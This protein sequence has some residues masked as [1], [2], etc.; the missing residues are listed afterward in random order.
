[1][2]SKEVEGAAEVEE[3]TVCIVCGGSSFAERWPGLLQCDTCQFITTDMHSYAGEDF[4]KLYGH[5]Y[6]HGDEYHDYIAEKAITQKS[7]KLRM[8]KL[9]RFL[10]SARHQSV[11]EIGS[12]YGFFLDLVKDRFAKTTGTDVAVEGV[13][14][15]V[16]PGA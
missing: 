4:E 7:F 15:A 3:D 13:E 1:M 8:R 14:Y 6:F 5:D 12:A 10:D 9:D 16:E 2:L 11:L